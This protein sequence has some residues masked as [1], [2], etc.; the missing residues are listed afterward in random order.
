MQYGEVILLSINE[1]KLFIFHV[2]E[3]LFWLF[4]K[5]RCVRCSILKVL[6]VDVDNVKEA[7][8]D[9]SRDD[10]HEPEV[11]DGVLVPAA[12][13]AGVVKGLVD[14]VGDVDHVEVSGV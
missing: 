13:Q 11:G 14:L 7:F 10:A 2:H 6:F 3:T 9:E 12:I 5:L 8:W 1:R 4:W